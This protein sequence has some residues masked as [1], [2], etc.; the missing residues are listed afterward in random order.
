M[1]YRRGF[2]LGAVAVLLAAATPI[3]SVA[4][5]STVFHSTSNATIESLDSTKYALAVSTEAIK[6]Y[7][8]GLYTY[9]KTNQVV[10]GMVTGQPQ[11]NAAKTVYTFTIRAA[12]WSNGTAVTA[13]DFVYAWQRLANPKTAS[14]NAYQIDIIKNGAAVRAGKKSVSELGVKALSSHKLQVT[15]TQPVPYLKQ[16]LTGAS[17]VPINRKYAEA[18]GAKY[19]TSAK[20]VI[21]NGPFIVKGWTGINDKWTYVRNANYWD[22]KNVKLD[23]ATI[24]VV[25]ESATAAN[26]F[27]NQQID[28]AVLGDSNL[29]RYTGKKVLHKATT[30]TI[31]Y[32]S[33]NNKRTTTSNRHLRLALAQAFNKKSLTKNVLKDGSTPLNG[34][35]PTNFAKSPSGKDYRNST[36]QFLTYAPSKAKANWKLAQKELNKKKVTL[37]LLVADT[38]QAKNVGEYL[39]GQIEKNLAG[40]TI[41]I[42]SVPVA[43]RIAAE[44]AGNYDLAFGTWAPDYADPVDFLS[45][46][47]SASDLNFSKYQNSSYDQKLTAITSTLATNTTARWQKM[48]AAEKQLIQ[49][50]AALAPVYQAGV[51]YLQ[52]GDVSGLNLSPFGSIVN[53]KYVDVK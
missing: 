47:Q 23:K 29:Q 50:D 43:Q 28:Y 44:K 38:P 20:H 51:T 48:Q 13:D 7:A 1:H 27:D 17:F 46:Y 32:I 5:K 19:G 14:S 53:Y 3:S 9:G 26:L 31:G 12:K 36:G 49:Q 41:S 30:P 15:L 35:I 24:Q 39:Q 6:A 22:A 34:L 25:K 4:A 52:R 37:E 40:V 2:I 21:A 10:P 33:I 18:Q 11:V 8:E 45:L 42:K 16:Y